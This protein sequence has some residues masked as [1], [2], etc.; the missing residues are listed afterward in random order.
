MPRCLRGAAAV[1]VSARQRCCCDSTPRSPVRLQVG[2]TLHIECAIRFR[3]HV[4]LC[5]GNGGGAKLTS[6]FLRARLPDVTILWP[7]VKPAGWIECQNYVWDAPDNG[8][9]PSGDELAAAL[10]GLPEATPAEGLQGELAP[11]DPPARD[12]RD[13]MFDATQAVLA[14]MMAQGELT[15]APVT[16]LRD[17]RIG[18]IG[19]NG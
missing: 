4:F 1:A 9:Q 19:R 5:M 3:G 7:F 12:L 15:G 16:V 11:T 6:A 8:A 10:P 2:E 17:V 14:C 18:R 13:E